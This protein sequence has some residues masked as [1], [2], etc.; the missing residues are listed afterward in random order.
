MISDGDDVWF[1]TKEGMGKRAV[2][3]V[4]K[5]EVVKVPGKSGG[6]VQTWVRYAHGGESWEVLGETSLWRARRREVEEDTPPS[7][8]S[9]QTFAV[10]RVTPPA[11]V[12]AAWKGKVKEM[13]ARRERAVEERE[14][15]AERAG[16]VL[17]GGLGTGSRKDLVVKNDL[18]RVGDKRGEM[19]CGEKMDGRDFSQG[20]GDGTEEGLG[21]EEV[22]SDERGWFPEGLTWEWIATAKIFPIKRIPKSVRLLWADV[23]VKT[24]RGVLHA[25]GDNRRWRLLFALPKLCLRLPRRGGKKKRKAFEAAPFILEQLR[26]AIVGDWKGLWEEARGAVKQK[27]RSGEGEGTLVGIRERVTSLVEEGQFTKAVQALDAAGIHKLDKSVLEMLR[28]KH[29]PG[30]GLEQN[31][32]EPGESAQFEAEDVQKA[33]ASFRM[34]TAPGGSR[35]R[36]SYLQDALTVPAGDSEA[37]LT[38]TLTGVVNLLA[39]GGAPKESAIWIAGA[40]LYPLRKKDGGVRPVAVGEVFRRLV[41]KCFCAKFKVRSETLF[42]EVGQVG[43]GVKGGAEAAVSAVRRALQKGD[44]RFCVLKVDLENAFNSIDR[45]AVLLA[46]RAFFPEVETWFRFCYGDPAKLFCEGE[47]LPFGSAQGVQQGDPLGPLLFALGL[48]SVCASL[49]EGVGKDSLTVWYLDDGTVVGDAAEV[50]RA[51]NLILEGVKKLGLNVN[52]KKCE[53]FVPQGLHGDLPGELAEVPVVQGSGFELLGAPVGEKAF[54]EEYVRNRV[55]KIEAALKHLELI[56][57]PQVELLLIRSCLAFP[58]FVFALR[59]APPDDIAGAVAHFDQMISSVLT[60]RLGI[61]LTPEQQL[62]ARLPLAMG[63]LGVERAVDVVE[64][65]YLGN[66]LSTSQLVGRLLGEELADLG[67]LRGVQRAFVSWK[68]KTG[69]ELK[70]VEEVTSLKEFQTREGKLHP[71]RVLASFVHQSSCAKLLASAPTSREELRLRAVFR[72]DAGAWWNVLPVKKLGFKFDR[73]EFLVL[74]K[75]WLGLPIYA[76]QEGMRRVC[77]EGK[78]GTEMDGMG[79]HAVVCPYGPSR[80]AR[81]DGVNKVWAFS[82]KGAGLAVKLEAYTE[83]GTMRRSADTLV[84]AWDFGRSAAHDWTVGH[85][86][87]KAALEPKN[88][89]NPNFVLE[90]AECHKDS[91]AKERC[92]LR[93]LAFVPLAMDTFGG[94]GPA[95]EKAISVAVAHAR[96]FR[97]N[98]LCDRALSRRMLLQRLQVAV[99]R[100]VSRQLLRRL[101]VGDE[102]EV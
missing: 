49:K 44:G 21:P 96:I 31:E 100:G 22:D 13:E 51:W 35:F 40:P 56:D 39:R 33:I 26:R 25:P 89:K 99:M 17:R 43:V 98:A 101:G 57:D 97:G 16:T 29:P 23:L 48:F 58:R 91:Y 95:A 46:V 53:L 61:S 41:S 34:G 79:D 94:V 90:Q 37:R 68:E 88:V 60:E 93:G 82:L 70:K 78:C 45:Q 65:A 30:K 85:V 84:D 87:Q 10:K 50:A 27:K 54:C 47:V 2:S 1:I 20:L 86:L 14:K 59:S 69:V 72:K 92:Q 12:T 102:D 80:T 7:V 5:G 62:Q 63:G 9:N 11:Y 73:D 32:G 36:A 6:L 67:E 18:E 15:R 83:P 55:E 42:V 77:P 74:V 24:L 28:E 38:G 75:W 19:E 4:V 81:H 8:W 52:K 3:C 71:Q 66:L 76:L 64:S